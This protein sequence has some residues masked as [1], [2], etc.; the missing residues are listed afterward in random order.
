[1]ENSQES[2]KPN[3]KYK[4]WIVTISVAIPSAVAILFGIRIPNVE[5]L[6]F[7]HPFYASLNAVTAVL[8]VCAYFSIKQK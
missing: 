7:L 4:K 3:L 2:T 8:L 1:M 5:P 6:T